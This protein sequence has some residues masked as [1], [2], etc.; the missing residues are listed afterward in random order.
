M[1]FFL[2]LYERFL[3]YKN[4]IAFAKYLGVNVGLDCRFL[5]IS[6]S[7]FGSEP[8]LISIGNHVTLTGGI[9]FITH[10]G[11]VWVLREK[12]PKIDCF[13]KITIGNN[14]FI[15]LNSV[16]MPNS[17]IGDNIVIGAGSLV[18]GVLEKDTVYAGVPV[19]KI[20]TIDEYESKI[21]KNYENTK[22]MSKSEKMNYLLERF[23]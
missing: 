2:Y 22:H 16:I 13:G 8:Y 18:R 15:G 12:Y 11:G 9:R 10:D 19:R 20:M 21:L 6:K 7:T 1:R 14:V 23:K 3:K 5:G 4:P 17:I